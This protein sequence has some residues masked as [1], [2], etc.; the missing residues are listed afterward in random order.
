MAPPLVAKI[1]T[2]LPIN[3]TTIGYGSQGAD[4]SA[5]QGNLY[6]LGYLGDIDIDGIFGEK[7]LS[8]V[9]KFQIE[10]YTKEDGIVGQITWEL[11]GIAV[12]D[13]DM[14]PTAIVSETAVGENNS[15][16]LWISVGLISI[17]IYAIT[18]GKGKEK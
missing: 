2:N 15:S 14:Q 7:T 8:A 12:R 16:I 6:V 5:L 11:L 18:H 9:K 3:R 17:F 4:V 10:H 13:K 1:E